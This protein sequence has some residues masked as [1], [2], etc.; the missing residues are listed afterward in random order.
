MTRTTTI[1]KIRA[2]THVDTVVLGT[3]DQDARDRRQICGRY[4]PI[5]ERGARLLALRAGIPGSSL[6]CCLCT[7]QVKGDRCD[8]LGKETAIDCDDYEEMEGLSI[9]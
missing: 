1:F 6:E 7:H 2:K 9:L 8:V 5:P 4:D 3:N